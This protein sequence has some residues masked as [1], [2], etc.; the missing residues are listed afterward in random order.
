MRRANVAATAGSESV[1]STRST[2]RTRA[3]ACSCVTAWAPHPTIPTT[4]EPGLASTSVAMAEAAPVRSAVSRVE[5][6]I[7]TRWPLPGS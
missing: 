4:T 5:S 2:G 1:T 7:A 6:T 3:I